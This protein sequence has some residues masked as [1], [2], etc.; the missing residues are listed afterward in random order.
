MSTELIRVI[1]VIRIHGGRQVQSLFFL[2]AV[3]VVR[4]SPNR[5]LICRSPTG[6]SVRV[7]RFPIFRLHIRILSNLIIHLER[8]RGSI[9]AFF[10]LCFHYEMLHTHGPLPG[11]MTFLSLKEI[12]RTT[13]FLSMWNILFPRWTSVYFSNFH[14]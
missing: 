7:R 2:C 14:V 1:F 13:S 10:S 6:I 8:R 12:R 5:V 4:L 9:I 3:T 11:I